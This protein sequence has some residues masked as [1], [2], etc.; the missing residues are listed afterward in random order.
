M[1]ASQ[2]KV[3]IVCNQRVRDMSLLPTDLDRLSAIADWEWLH[4][5]GGVAFGPNE[6]PDAIRQLTERVG[7]VDCL[8][9]CHGSPDDQRRRHGRRP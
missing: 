6:E 4:L 3:L 9:V 2:H 1:T 7:D 5:E 8:V